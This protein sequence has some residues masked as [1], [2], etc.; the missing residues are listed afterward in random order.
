MENIQN[1]KPFE[2]GETIEITID[3]MTEQGRGIGKVKGFT[4]FVADGL[5]RGNWMT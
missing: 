3:D 2:K 5:N 4:F 1:E